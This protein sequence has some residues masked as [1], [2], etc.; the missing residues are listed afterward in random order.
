M[1]RRR[2]SMVI[3]L[4]VLLGGTAAAAITI[5][6]PSASQSAAARAA[7][8]VLTVLVAALAACL[9]YGRARASGRGRDLTL[10]WG[11]SLLAVV[12]G[13]CSLLPAIVLQETDGALLQAD[14]IAR[15]LIA[16][17]LAVAA[18]AP[19]YLIDQA[20]RRMGYAMGAG[21]LGVALALLV[22]SALSPA[23]AAAA[24]AAASPP[25]G[26]AATHLTAMLLAVVAGAAFAGRAIRERTELEAW[27]AAA[28]VL[29]GG[30]QLA[31]GL[32]PA[33]TPDRITTGDLLRSAAALVLLAGALRQLGTYLSAMA[34]RA[35][36]QER[37]RIARDL[38][39]GLA[40]ELAYIA[41][42]A[43]GMAA[44][45]GDP[46][47]ARVAEAAAFALDQS[48]LAIASLSH[49]PPEPLGPALARAAERIASRAGGV[50]RAD[51]QAGVDVE[52]AVR[53]DLMRIVMEATTNAVRHS[54]AS[55]VSLSLTGGE[56]VVLQIAD[57][58]VGFRLDGRAPRL[59]S[60]FGL[61]SMQERAERAG[62][63]LRVRS[64]PGG[65]TVV[66]VRIA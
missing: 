20:G 13:A 65:G 24:L 46:A 62:G 37:R 43:P 41:A 11:V 44:R 64:R 4:V 14:A 59:Y 38:H 28:V 1:V 52:P 50:V 5:D 3:A 8:E 29:L 19:A 40:Q 25:T 49:D 31:A 48:R 2:P 27:V 23:N 7:L 30:A 60:G 66:E 55:E 26:Q 22:I 35:V 45:S 51:L 15:L 21:L 36:A 53:G 32:S 54:G 58:G 6:A 34:R 56:A 61:T 17:V 10:A 12:E 9:L 39:D 18:L 42:H 16:V 63:R 57:D 33:L 47:A